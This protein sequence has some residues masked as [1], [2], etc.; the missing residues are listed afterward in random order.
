MLLSVG[1]GVLVLVVAAHV[2]LLA[3][4]RA[5]LKHRADH[6]SLT[7]L[8]NASH[9]IERLTDALTHARRNGD[10]VAVLLIDL[11]RF[12]DVND[13][14]GHQV[15]DEVLRAVAARLRG[16]IREHDTVARLSGDEF[17]VVVPGQLLLDDFGA[18]A[19]KLQRSLS[20]PFVMRGR[21]FFMT[22]SLGIARYPV[23]GT[24]AEQLLGH[25]DAAMYRAKARSGAGYEF[26]TPEIWDQAQERLP[27]ET[28]LRLAL[29][30]DE[31]LLHY[32]PKIDLCTDNVTG[33][34]ALVRWQHP[35]LGLL[36]PARFLSVAEQTSLIVPLGQWVLR[37]ACAQA[38]A[39]QRSGLAPLPVAVN[40]SAH[41]LERARLDQL[42]E[43]ALNESGLDPT[44]LE[45]ELTES[46][47]VHDSANVARTLEAIRD[48]GVR[49]TIDDFGTGYGALSYLS[50]FRVD[51]LKIDRSF[52]AQ[53]EVSPTG[54]EIV[55]GI[56]ALA[57]SLGLRVTAEG[58]ETHEQLA[59]LREVGSDEAQG[60]L[61]GPPLAAPELEQLLLERPNPDLP[62]GTAPDVPSRERAPVLTAAMSGR[63]AEPTTPTVDSLWAACGAD[64]T[65]AEQSP[66]AAEQLTVPHA[67]PRGDTPTRPRLTRK[68]ATASALVLSSL[69]GGLGAAGALPDSVQEMVGPGLRQVGIAVPHPKGDGAPGAPS[70]SPSPPSPP[71]PFA[72]SELRQS[73]PR[74]S[75]SR[76]PMPHSF[77]VG[78]VDQTISF[79]PLAN[80]TLADSPVTVSATASSGLTV[81][82]STTTPAVCVA[83]GTS[84]TL[85]GVGT[86]T[87]QADQAGDATYNPAPPVTQSFEVTS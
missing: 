48:M 77:A 74:R 5:A 37:I 2:L 80:A 75:P 44:L 65:G 84:I 52:V 73:T 57:Q 43:D 68:L 12:K 21:P 60:Y 6:D 59:F 8:P 13:S 72:P 70:A 71:A 31:F 56:V 1:T 24:T 87:V 61:L 49:C 3:R 32:Q 54:R 47:L 82:F 51:G 41:Q 86:C 66:D 33:V 29:E 64:A 76:R 39:W 27:L 19:D 18:L 10:G 35:H 23:D 14:L 81:T 9:L 58:V 17:V 85:V 67:D 69:L 63:I 11:D 46:R 53:I 30:R 28:N 78:M 4:D 38:A 42:V 15:G 62:T 22:A 16:S 26:S 36:P 20:Q 83:S 40:V 7:G 55:R 45:L 79:G 34:E 25:A 50:R